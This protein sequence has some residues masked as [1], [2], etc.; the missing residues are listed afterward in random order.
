[1]GEDTIKE[2]QMPLRGWRTTDKDSQ[3]RPHSTI[4]FE[5]QVSTISRIDGA[6]LAEVRFKRSGAVSPIDIR[7]SVVSSRRR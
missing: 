7:S 6:V 1:M 2:K 4:S 5:V 3:T